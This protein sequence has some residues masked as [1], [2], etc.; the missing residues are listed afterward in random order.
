MLAGPLSRGTAA[1]RKHRIRPRNIQVEV[2]AIPNRVA[3]MYDGYAIRRT[4][5]T[6][7]ESRQ[8]AD[9]VAVRTSAGT[10]E[11]DGEHVVRVCLL[12]ESDAVNPA[13]E[14]IFDK[15]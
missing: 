8:A 3:A 15:R 5:F 11:D 4:V 14:A 6:P 13:E 10:A 12:P 7:Q 1:R 9:T 2:M